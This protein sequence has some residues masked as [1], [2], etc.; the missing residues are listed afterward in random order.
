MSI[1]S[2][3]SRIETKSVQN[4]SVMP[5]KLNMLEIKTEFVRNESETGFAQ[6]EVT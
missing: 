5:T 6:N 1:K 3:M 4:E 2:N